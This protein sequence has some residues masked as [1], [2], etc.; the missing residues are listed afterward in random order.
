V[1]IILYADDQILMTTSEDDLQN[2][3]I[4]P[5]PYSKKWLYPAQKQKQWQSG[6]TTYRW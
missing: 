4:P 6:G 3:G 2:N 5:E 1:N